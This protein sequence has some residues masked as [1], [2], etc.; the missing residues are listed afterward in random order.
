MLDSIKKAFKFFERSERALE[1]RSG[2]NHWNLAKCKIVTWN[3]NSIEGQFNHGTW[4][5]VNFPIQS[6]YRMAGVQ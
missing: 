1:I 6:C 3:I 5:Y 4:L 2:I